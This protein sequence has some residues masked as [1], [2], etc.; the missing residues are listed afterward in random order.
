M[1]LRLIDTEFKNILFRLGGEKYRRFIVSYLNWEVLV[2]KLLAERSHP[3][4]VEQHVLYVGVEN[5]SWMQELT[6]LK[7]DILSRLRAKFDADINEIVFV[8]RTK[9]RKK[10]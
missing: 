7:S 6:L 8:I 9:R 2:G 3:I 5:N 4:K 10:K 1:G